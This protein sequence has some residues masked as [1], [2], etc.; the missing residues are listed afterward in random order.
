MTLHELLESHHGS[1]NVDDKK[2]EK[3]P[4]DSGRLKPPAADYLF[5]EQAKNKNA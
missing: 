4:G 5:V 1:N 3:R 2:A